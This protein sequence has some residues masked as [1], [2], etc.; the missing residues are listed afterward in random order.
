MG[1]G[2]GEQKKGEKEVMEDCALLHRHRTEEGVVQLLEGLGR[3]A[4]KHRSSQITTQF[5]SLPN[6]PSYY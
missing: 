6:L 2:R 4:L 3:K 1:I 5:K